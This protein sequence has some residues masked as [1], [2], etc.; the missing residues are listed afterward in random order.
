M[1][2]KRRE[3]E[4]ETSILI[5]AKILRHLDSILAK[6][7]EDR[8]LLVIQKGCLVSNVPDDKIRNWYSSRL[9][10]MSCD[11]TFVVKSHQ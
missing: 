11:I 1:S 5:A 7:V 9:V 10:F 4:Q 8:V 2:K 3:S 6:R